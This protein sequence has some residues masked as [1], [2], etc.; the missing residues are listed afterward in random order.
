MAPSVHN[1]ALTQVGAD[2]PIS[3][4]GMKTPTELCRQKG[5]RIQASSHNPAG[6]YIRGLGLGGGGR[7][8]VYEMVILSSAS[9]V[10]LTLSYSYY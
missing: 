6:M 4:L 8:Y 1:T 2:I 10:S 9:A 7:E 3:L 5:R